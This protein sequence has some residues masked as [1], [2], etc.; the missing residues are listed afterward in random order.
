VF[1]LSSRPNEITQEEMS[2]NLK[3]LLF[4][5][6]F[7]LNKKQLKKERGILKEMVKDFEKGRYEKYISEEENEY[8]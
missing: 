4:I 6:K 8:E 3:E 2:D 7:I 1:I 5:S